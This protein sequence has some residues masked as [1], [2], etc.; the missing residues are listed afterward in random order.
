VSTV[1]ITVNAVNDAPVAND[2]AIATDGAAKAIAL[3]ASDVEGSALTYAIGSGPAHGTLSGIAPS[4]TYTPAAGYTGADSFTFTANDGQASSNVATVFITVASASG[5]PMAYSQSVQLA[6]D[7]VVGIMLTGSDP[8]GHQLRFRIGQSP[9]HG[10]LSGEA[11]SLKYTPDANYNG[12]DSFTFYVVAGD[13]VSN[14]AVVSIMTTPVN[15]SPI[16]SR[17]KF[18][19]TKGAGVTGRLAATDVDGDSL[20][21]RVIDQ[22]RK[23]HVIVTATGDF[24]FIPEPGANGE[25]SFTYVANDGRADSNI[26]TV[27]IISNNGKAQD[28]RP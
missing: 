4:L 6:E 19:T 11:P 10:K 5:T 27:Q 28:P 17:L 14:N 1:S 9:A 22:P 25:E 2:Q 12:A 20:T 26:G 21:Y 23:G 16:A 8:Q 7:T 3:S 13:R 24:T 15:D 18:M